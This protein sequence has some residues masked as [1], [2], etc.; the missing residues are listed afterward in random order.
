MNSIW[1]MNQDTPYCC[2]ARRIKVLN[3]VRRTP[4]HT[5]ILKSI[6]NAKAVPITGNRRTISQK[7]LNCEY[8]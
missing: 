8:Q 3:P 4:I 2:N 7:K 5:G 6:F 1:E